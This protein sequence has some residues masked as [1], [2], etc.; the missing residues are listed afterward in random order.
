MPHSAG[1]V[2]GGVAQ[3]DGDHVRG[4]PELRIEHGL[5]HD[6]RVAVEREVVGDEQRDETDHRGHDVAEA[7]SLNRFE[8][9]REQ[10]D[11]PAD[12]DGGRVQVRD[13]RPAGD[14]NAGDQCERCGGRT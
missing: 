7:E 14:V 8:D 2:R 11:G 6:E 13:R 5:Q 1:D 4:E 12:E 9:E 3:G 10:H